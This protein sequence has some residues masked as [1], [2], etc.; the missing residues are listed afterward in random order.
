MVAGEYVGR[1]AIDAY[2]CI[3][4]ITAAY[5][6]AREGCREQPLGA[7]LPVGQAA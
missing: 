3:E 5:R 6:S 1:E 4:L 2:R 7:P